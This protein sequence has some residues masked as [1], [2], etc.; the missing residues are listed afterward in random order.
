MR[1]GNNFESFLS[2][3]EDI[4]DHKQ[5]VSRKKK[6]SLQDKKKT[7]PLEDLF[8]PKQTK[9]QNRKKQKPQQKR[10]WRLQLKA[11]SPPQ[12]ERK[13]SQEWFIPSIQ[14]FFSQLQPLK[15][16]TGCLSLFLF[17]FI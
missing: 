12:K 1:V 11:R 6:P 10:A 14:T 9:P 13:S 8:I 3:E 16:F 5:E 4:P 17:L 15:L 7:Q 2:E